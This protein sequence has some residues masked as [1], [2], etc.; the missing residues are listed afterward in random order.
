VPALI[1]LLLVNAGPMLHALY[2]SFRFHYISRPMDRR[3]A[4][5]D[6][7]IQSLVDPLFLHS[8][9]IT[10]EFSGVA[11]LLELVLGLALAMLLLRIPR[12]KNAF[13]AILIVPMMI[14]QI[15]VGLMWRLLLHPDLGIINY[16]LG[17]IGIRGPN[18]LG[19]P[20]SALLTLIL[21]D[22]WQWTPFMML[23]LYA[24]L[25]SLPTAPFEA[26]RIDGANVYQ[27]F[28]RLTLPLLA[29]VLLVAIVVRSI[30]AL[31][32][33]ALVYILTEGG[34]GTATEVLS[35]HIYK[36]GFVYS[37]FGRAAAQ[38]YVLSTLIMLITV[39]YLR[40]MRRAS[41]VK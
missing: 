23:L 3:F 7:Y 31:K 30:D 4:G 21:V 2:T 13:L 5:L 16:L 6:N 8:L 39:A 41:G 14:T 34:P 11:V 36:T 1:G 20:T 27:L 15:A 24:G 40:L 35:F 19:Q 9:R 26:A 10:L 28:S 29:P 37:N 38:S 25:L 33:Y 32:T 18:W 17:V 22:A 12:F